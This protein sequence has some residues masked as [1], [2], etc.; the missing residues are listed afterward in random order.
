MNTRITGYWNIKKKKLKQR[1]KN[2]S[3]KDL[4]FTE[5]KEKEM[6]EL[7]GNKLG[8]T[9]QELLEIIVTL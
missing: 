2:L 1:F 3:D 7:L 9:R 8:K 4:R 5:G 6:I